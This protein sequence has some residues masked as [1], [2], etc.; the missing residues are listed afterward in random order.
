M[1]ISARNLSTATGASFM[2]IASDIQAATGAQVAFADSLALANKAV[3]S[4]IGADKVAEFATL[5]TKAAQTFGGTTTDAMNR[6]TDAVLRGR[7]ELVNK[8]GIVISAD[9]AYTKYSASIGKTVQ[10][11]T[12]FEK[13]LAISNAIVEEGNKTLGET[14]IDPN[15]YEV[16]ATTM[17]DVVQE[18]LTL[19]EG[20][21][22]NDI[23]NSFNNLK[24]VILGLGLA[25]A[26]TIL[27]KII[28]DQQTLLDKAKKNAE[29]QKQLQ[30]SIVTKQKA[31]KA[32]LKALEDAKTEDV[33]KAVRKR[34]RE[35]LKEADAETKESLKGK[36]S[37][38][39]RLMTT[40]ENVPLTGQQQAGLRKTLE[41]GLKDTGAMK[42]VPNPILR[43]MLSDLDILQN[44]LPPA[45]VKIKG[46]FRTLVTK[47]QTGALSFSVAMD[48]AR[49]SVTGFQEKLARARA[50]VAAQG[51]FAKMDDDIGKLPSTIAKVG[52]AFNKLISSLGIIGVAFALAN[53]AIEW[54]RK[55]V[56]KAAGLNKKFAEEMEKLD[57][58]MRESNLTFE[59]SVDKLERMGGGVLSTASDFQKGLTIVAN[60]LK[61]IAGIS[62]AF[63]TAQ[64][65][66][67]GPRGV[68]RLE[69]YNQSLERQ[70]ERTKQISDKIAELKKEKDKIFQP[71]GR[72]VLLDEVDLAQV[73]KLNAQI[74]N[75]G[76]QRDFVSDMIDDIN[77]KVDDAELQI[78]AQ[79]QDDLMQQQIANIVEDATS[80]FERLEEVIKGTLNLENFSLQQKLE[81]IAPEDINKLKNAEKDFV[82]LTNAIKD[83]I[84]AS[85]KNEK[86]LSRQALALESLKASA[87]KGKKGIDAIK[88]AAKAAF[89]EEGM[90]RDLAQIQAA[91]LSV[92]TSK[93]G[94]VVDRL[95]ASIKALG[96]ITTK[97]KADIAKDRSVDILGKEF[98]TLA[99]FVD[100]SRKQL[101]NL[102]A[103]GASSDAALESL[104]KTLLSA[105]EASKEGAGTKAL[106]IFKNLELQVN[107]LRVE[108]KKLT[109]QQTAYNELALDTGFKMKSSD[110]EERLR[111]TTEL[112]GQEQ[113]LNEAEI[114]LLKDANETLAVEQAQTDVNDE[115]IKRNERQIAKLTRRNDEIK[116]GFATEKEAL[117]VVREKA[118]YETEALKHAQAMKTIKDSLLPLDSVSA[119]L[120]R[121]QIRDT[122]L[123]DKIADNLLKKS[124]LQ[125][126]L[127]TAKTE[128]TKEQLKF[129]IKQTD[130]IDEQLKLQERLNKLRDE[131]N[132]EDRA[133]AFQREGQIEEAFLISFEKQKQEA[134]KIAA[135]S[136]NKLSAGF[137]NGIRAGVQNL[138]QGIMDGNASLSDAISAMGDVIST[139][140]VE[141]ATDQLV[142]MLLDMF[143]LQVDW[144][145]K[146]ADATGNSEEHLKS[147]RESL[148]G[149]L[150]KD[151]KSPSGESEGFF[152]G[153]KNFF[154][155]TWNKWFGTEEVTDPNSVRAT[156]D[157]NS[158]A[159][160]RIAP[161]TS[162]AEEAMESFTSPM[163]QTT[164]DT[165]MPPT[166]TQIGVSDDALYIEAAL[167]DLFFGTADFQTQT[168][169]LL[170]KILT[171]GA[172]NA[173]EEAPTGTATV[174]DV[175]KSEGG[176]AKS[177]KGLKDVK[178]ATDDAA[179]ATSENTLSLGEATAGLAALG[180]LMGENSAITKILQVATL[181][182][183]I[184]TIAN[185]ASKALPFANGGVIGTSGPI[186]L[187]NGGIATRRQLYEIGEGRKNEAVVPLPNN[188]E[189]PVV[190]TGNQ[191]PTVINNYDFSNA[192]PSTERR[193]RAE[194]DMK[195]KE[196]FG[197]VFTEID[198]GGVYAKKTGRR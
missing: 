87:E 162:S 13:R 42:A 185:T 59:T 148:T 19:A 164:E 133:R 51:I 70:K 90:E 34:I 141:T 40:D 159:E 179:N 168:I 190:M 165:N 136:I 117:A 178:K 177:N 157:I 197:K 156:Q 172:T 184:A 1:V 115:L 134:T 77:D 174:L 39:Q 108:T 24:S 72:S 124:Q 2:N 189:I 131:T 114:K 125:R 101:K 147:I 16:L 103:Q 65:K 78:E 106:K 186:G 89:P 52:G 30:D 63:I 21:L 25:M 194:M 191:E 104:A 188:R 123:Q 26:G 152:A 47:A 137:A 45:E 195:A 160:N 127:D 18:V 126:E 130:N 3:A 198:R 181:A 12:S 61:D 27:K 135:D 182:N 171:S 28:P 142:S 96:D 7:T 161:M 43:G 56:D 6:F 32:K 5:A 49:K 121:T 86:G 46:F 66:I 60:A 57:E 50:T 107:N 58:R 37:S 44:K 84:A 14:V 193:L 62:G 100:D 48:S 105:E 166:A 119:M 55:N 132:F 192:D 41:A 144:D 167:N 113:L 196:T 91:I 11:L 151:D 120:A 158:I 71:K 98:G 36:T 169:E 80:K 20:G 118:K 8:L 38:I 128:S 153:I 15:P 129:Q 176:E 187:A 146:I 138:M 143:G 83:N 180:G 88:E 76:A 33:I 94:E 150:P 122:Q 22:I 173:T 29:Y 69:S 64:E 109:T 67:Y 85:E 102:E 81:V 95:G 112:V 17:R 35:R 183:T 23:V 79:M 170:T 68:S 139:T 97:F 10:E 110:V 53:T 74:R 163:P 54:W 31:T 140:L 116:K 175:P 92:F 149:P 145:Q 111:L 93:K 99:T 82:V 9:E 154:T 4:G 155:D 75:L 73:R